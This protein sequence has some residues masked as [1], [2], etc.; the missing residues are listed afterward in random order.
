MKGRGYDGDGDGGLSR[1]QTH[2]AMR[3][4][5]VFV[6]DREIVGKVWLFIL[7]SKMGMSC[8]DGAARARNGY[9][10]RLERNHADVLQQVSKM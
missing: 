2:V 7:P 1:W 10:E 3:G 6:N 5:R 9:E 4:E 8:L